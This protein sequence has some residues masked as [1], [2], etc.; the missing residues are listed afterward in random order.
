[1]TKILLIVD[2]WDIT[3][4]DD[5]VNFLDLK[6]NDVKN[7]IRLSNNNCSDIINEPEFCCVDE[8]NT[9]DHNLTL[10]IKGLD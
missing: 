10:H 3:V 2:G 1:M 6:I 9:R 7:E 4:V 5:D 8:S